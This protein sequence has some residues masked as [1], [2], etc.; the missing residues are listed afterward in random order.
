MVRAIPSSMN[1]AAKTFALSALTAVSLAATAQQQVVKPPQAQAW[2]DVATFSGMGMP[3]MGGPGG[4]NPMSALGGLFGGGG[5]SGGK[6]N[7]LMTQAGS[8]GRYVDVTLLSRRNP[9]L[10]EAAQNVPP[11]FLSPALKLVAPRD[12]APPRDDE[13]VVPERDPQ[14]PE[15]KLYLY[16]GCGETVRPGQPKVID[17][18]SANAAEIAQA[19]QSRRAT[20]RGAHSAN[21]RPHWPNPADGRALAEG[22]SLAGGHAFSGNGVPESF[23]FN[24]PAAQDLMPPMQLQQADQ[25]GAIALS[26]NAQPNVRAFFVAGLG[27][28]GRG[29]MVLWSSSELPDAGMG[30][31]DYQ[32]NPAV[33]RWLREK[34]LL[35]PTTTSCTVPKGVFVGEGAM[36]RAIA[37][38][39]ELNLAHPPRPAD[40]KV[41]WEPE[42]AL[43]VRVKSVAS[44]VVGMPSMDEAMRGAPREN[45]E[46]Q[47]QQPPEKK[48]GPL[49]ILRGVLGR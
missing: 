11:G 15:G 4:G 33:D 6:V 2:I 43:K 19:F 3:G 14:R 39:H 9:Q 12:V 29:E 20:Q 37:Y 27:A 1:A 7:F 32:T 49:D 16:W 41:A 31:I 24:I 47:A 25:G 36:L 8:A 42:W 30:L 26:W 48:P 38:G 28:R 13:D 34:V 10:A 17:F 23:R 18:A 45:A 22:A 46:P 40:P 44:A 35:A 21:G 5:G